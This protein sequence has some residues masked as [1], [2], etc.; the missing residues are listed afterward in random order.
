M[1]GAGV[2]DAEGAAGI[3]DE[4]V[5]GVDAGLLELEGDVY[6]EA[7]RAG[8]GGAGAV[9]GV[10]LEGAVGFDEVLVVRGEGGQGLLGLQVRVVAGP[11]LGVFALRQRADV[12]G[13]EFDIDLLA[14]S[15]AG[16]GQIDDRCDATEREPNGNDHPNQLFH[17]LSSSLAHGAMISPPGP[18]CRAATVR[19]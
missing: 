1:A 7:F 11:G 4:F 13:K 3:A 14:V 6:G 15:R 5:V 9:D 16:D 2:V 17:G 12:G 10:A 19:R 8:E 18:Q